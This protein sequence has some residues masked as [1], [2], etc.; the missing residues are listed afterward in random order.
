MKLKLYDSLKGEVTE[1]AERDPGTLS[2]YSCGPTVYNDIHVGNA[3]PFWIAMVLKRFA[4]QRLGMP[5]RLGDQHHRRQRPHLRG[6][7]RAGRAID[8]DRRALRGA[9]IAATSELGLRPSR[10]RAAA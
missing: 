10:R 5:V 9:Y 7:A 1:V 8:G 3:R 4:E 6:G 2:V